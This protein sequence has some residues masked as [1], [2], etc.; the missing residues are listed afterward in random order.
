MTEDTGP[1]RPRNKS[2]MI[3]L[4]AGMLFLA[5][6]LFRGTNE[7]SPAIEAL[8]RSSFVSARIAG[9]PGEVS[10]GGSCKDGGLRAVVT[11]RVAAGRG[12]E[13]VVALDAMLTEDEWRYVSVPE[14]GPIFATYTKTVVTV[15]GDENSETGS[16][17]GSSSKEHQENAQERV[18]ATLETY[19]DPSGETGPRD[20]VELSFVVECSER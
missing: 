17:S 18:L 2:S 11:R 19:E 1:I 14:S 15:T 13:G 20:I 4:A 5:L 10:L 16:L 9:V 3:T 7:R 6:V 8:S 12:G